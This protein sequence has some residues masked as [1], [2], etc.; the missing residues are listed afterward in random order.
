M[1]FGTA[2]MG[3]GATEAPAETWEYQRREPH[4]PRKTHGSNG[5]NAAGLI[6]F[7]AWISQRDRE[8]TPEQVMDRFEVSRATAYRWLALWHEV[9][10]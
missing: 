8:P 1:T 10:P 9:A 5:V 3:C 4:S 7:G 6:R 2:S